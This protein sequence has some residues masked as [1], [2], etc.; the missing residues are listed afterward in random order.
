MPKALLLRIR[1][2]QLE[3]S[4]TYPSL[5]AEIVKHLDKNRT[6]AAWSLTRFNLTPP[7]EV[8]VNAGMFELGVNSWT[9][10]SDLTAHNLNVVFKECLAVLEDVVT[11]LEQGRLKATP[12]GFM[13]A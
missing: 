2:I 5:R 11:L 12:H 8:S 10:P 4:H 7:T 13:P 6:K 9:V 1:A 3:N